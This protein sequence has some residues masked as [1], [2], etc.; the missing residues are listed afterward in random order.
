MTSG[1]IAPLVRAGLRPERTR[2][3]GYRDATDLPLGRRLGSI[4]TNARIGAV[5]AERE[6]VTPDDVLLELF[7]EGDESVQDVIRRGLTPMRYVDALVNGL[8]PEDSDARAFGSLSRE[9]LLDGVT[10]ERVR[11]VIHNDPIT[12]TVLIVDV[13][14]KGFPREKTARE[15]LAE[16]VATAGCVRIDGLTRDEAARIAIEMMQHA[17]MLGSPLM[18]S[19]ESSS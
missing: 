16:Q 10:G 2:E 5:Q 8:G 9:A 6:E 1:D 7:R 11:L 14:A 13:L 19:L 3:L 15:A 17:R 18:V 12:P 4:V